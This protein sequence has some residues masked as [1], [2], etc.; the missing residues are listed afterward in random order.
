MVVKN[1]TYVCN[2]SN[3]KI[4]LERLWWNI[5]EKPEQIFT[6]Q[7]LWLDC[8]QYFVHFSNFFLRYTLWFAMVVCHFL[9]TST[10]FA[11]LFSSKISKMSSLNVGNRS[12]IVS[13]VKFWILV[14]FTGDFKWLFVRAAISN[15]CLEIVVHEPFSK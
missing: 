11:R 13:I 15:P 14:F 1:Q 8:L 7:P 10:Q 9:F 6:L 5:L 4:I 3:N 12:K 2:L